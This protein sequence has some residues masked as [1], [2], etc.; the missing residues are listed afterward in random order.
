MAH[1]FGIMKRRAFLQTAAAGVVAPQIVPSHVFGANDKINLGVIGCG[2]RGMQVMNNFLHIDDVRVVAVCDVDSH[3]YREH[4]TRTGK[5]LGLE[6]AKLNVEAHYGGNFNC[7]ATED[8]RE[9]CARKDLD[10]MLVATPDHWHALATLEALK[11]RLD[12]YCEKPVTHKFREG[13]QVVEAVA[14]QKAIFQVGSQQRSAREFQKAVTLVRNGVLGSVKKVEVG[15]P[16]GYKNM[17]SSMTPEEPPAQLDYNFWCGPAEVLPYMRARHHRWWRGHTAYGGGALMDFIGH[18]NDIAHWGLGLD[19]SGP[20]SVISK[21]WKPTPFD[22]YDTPADYTIHCEY[23][24]GIDWTIGSGLKGG[25][26]WIGENG[27]WIWVNRGK[28][29]ASNPAW[30]ADDFKI[31]GDFRIPPGPNHQ[32]NFV[33]S[34]RSRIPCLCEAET[35]HRSITPGHLGYVSQKLGGRELKWDAKA[36]TIIGDDEAQKLLTKLDYRDWETTA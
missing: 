12:V 24:G 10:A 25:T 2:G 4:P 27:S 35:G 16:T 20:V 31:E 29:G 14:N 5:P 22:C 17:A 6:P 18:H 32:R 34:I 23:P 13:Q 1:D 19:T 9:I 15:L 33:D 28:L 3:H 7:G 36:E 26:K 8:F 11:N 30:L 21:G